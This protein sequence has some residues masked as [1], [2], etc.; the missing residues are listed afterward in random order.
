MEL[1]FAVAMANTEKGR[2]DIDSVPSAIVV[3]VSSCIEV[4]LVFKGGW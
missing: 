1:I 3:T 2:I 4:L